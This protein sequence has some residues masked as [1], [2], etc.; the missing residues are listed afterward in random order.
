[1]S[2]HHKPSELSTLLT[3]PGSPFVEVESVFENLALLPML[4]KAWTEIASG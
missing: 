4:V 1:M 2:A 3:T